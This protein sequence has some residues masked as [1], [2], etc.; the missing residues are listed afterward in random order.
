MTTARSVPADFADPERFVEADLSS[1][2]GT[3]K[4]I[5]AVK[6]RFGTIDIVVNNVGGAAH[7]REDFLRQ[8]TNIGSKL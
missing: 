2:E 3:M 7:L 4:V 8:V 6:K 5:E 1:N